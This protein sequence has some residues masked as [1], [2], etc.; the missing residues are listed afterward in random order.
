[1]KYLY[2]IDP[3]R[4][5]S[6]IPFILPADELAVLYLLSRRGLFSLLTPRCSW[7]SCFRLILLPTLH[8]ILLRH[9]LC[10]EREP[11]IFLNR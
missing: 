9:G 7:L 6:P 10:N 5:L 8:G 3:S 4:C 2:T 11:G 1:M